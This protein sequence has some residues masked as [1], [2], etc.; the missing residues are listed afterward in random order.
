MRDR[1]HCPWCD[2]E[3]HIDDRFCIECGHEIGVMRSEDCQCPCCVRT[4]QMRF[5]IRTMNVQ[6]D[7]RR[8]ANTEDDPFADEYDGSEQKQK[9][10]RPPSPGSPEYIRQHEDYLKRTAPRGEGLTA[11]ID[12]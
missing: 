3:N 2:E 5:L 11:E 1:I 8:Y 6:I 4:E 9:A 12:D 7:E 10:Y